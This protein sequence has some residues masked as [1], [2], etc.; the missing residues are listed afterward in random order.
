[1]NSS[2]SRSNSESIMDSGFSALTYIN[3]ELYKN[4]QH[5]IN[6]YL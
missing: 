1:M 3:R 2:F 5:N 6:Y 4:G